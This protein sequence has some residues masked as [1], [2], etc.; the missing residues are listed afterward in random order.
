MPLGQKSRLR[1]KFSSD[2]VVSLCRH[3]GFVLF[4]NTISESHAGEDWLC[5]KTLARYHGSQSEKE[6]LALPNAKE[7]RIKVMPCC[8]LWPRMYLH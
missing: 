4:L 8:I 6:P 3:S 1:V 2:M 5:R 7:K